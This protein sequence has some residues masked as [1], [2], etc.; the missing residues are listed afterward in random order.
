M[1]DHGAR[2]PVRHEVVDGSQ[3]PESQ[4]VVAFLSGQKRNGPWLLAPSTRLVAVLGSVELDLREAQLSDGETIIELFCLLGSVEIIVPPGVRV[5]NEGDS[6]AG[7][8]EVQAGDWE[9]GRVAPVVRLRGSCYLGDVEVRQQAFGESARQA[10]KR[11]KLTR[12]G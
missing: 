1:S 10:R 5:L 9:P 7:N 12:G 8:F 11:R 2:L 6:F 4:G 3:L